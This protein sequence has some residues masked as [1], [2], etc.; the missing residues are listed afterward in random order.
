VAEQLTDRVRTA[1]ASV[2]RV[3]EKKMFGGLAFMVEGKMCVTVNKG[4]LLVRVDPDLSDA[5]AEKPGAEMMVMGKRRYRGY[6]RVDA[7]A[8]RTNENL[9]EWIDRAV[10]YN[11]RA[12][13]AVPKPRKRVT[14]G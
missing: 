3:E 6:V 2:P 1:L 10:D 4:R 5:L 12:K 14:N 7:E 9:R 13:P 11:S 8:L